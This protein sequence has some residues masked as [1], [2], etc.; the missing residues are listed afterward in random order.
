MFD[1]VD[2]PATKPALELVDGQLVQKTSPK[3]RHQ[4]LEVRWMLAL[5]TWGDGEAYHEWRHEFHAPGYRFA[6]LVPD[7]AYLSRA[8]IDELGEAAAESPPRAPEVAVEILSAGENER[9]L[10]WKIAA[11]LAAGALVVFV[12]DPPRRT[13]IAHARDGTTR[14]GPGE[15][16]THALMPGFAYEVDA[17]FAGLYLG[18]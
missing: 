12:V 8:A 15:V 2:I 18:E 7:V 13:V 1:R 4:E 17:M 16:V 6:S 9:R 10:A 5:R 14:F 3:R 11:Y